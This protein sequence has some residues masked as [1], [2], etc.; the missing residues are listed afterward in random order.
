MCVCVC[1]C[2]CVLP[3]VLCTRETLYGKMWS[4][5]SDLSRGDTAYTTQALDRHTD[6]TYFHEPCGWVPRVHLFT[7]SH[8]LAYVTIGGSHGPRLYD[9]GV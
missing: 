6:T 2:V 7:P 8:S 5:T 3:C 1:V 9:N 4:F